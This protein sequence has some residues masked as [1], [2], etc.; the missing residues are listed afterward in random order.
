MEEEILTAMLNNLEIAVPD[1][2]SMEHDD[3]ALA[4]K[5]YIGASDTS[6]LLDVNLYKTK[7]ELIVEKRTKS[8]TDKERAVGE[9]PVV[10]KGFDLE[11]F[12]MGKYEKEF[13][14]KLIKPPHMYCFPNQKYMAINYDGV[15][16]VHTS[17]STVELIDVE[18]K[19]V[20]MYGEKYYNKEV[21]EDDIR[22]LELV[23][24]ENESISEYVKR[25]ASVCGIPAYYYTQ[26]QQQIAGLGSSYGYLYAWFDKSWEG[27]R[28][29]IPRD[30]ITIN[31]IARE[32]DKLITKIRS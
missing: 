18:I 31:A 24:R 7:G 13:D 12:I 10:K 16:V 27:K 20:S 3:Y 2:Q 32:G 5:E 25:A 19:F 29:Y 8:I 26:V 1:I 28:F 22:Q 6:V 15:S 21:T 9:K 17:F 4:R 14:I 11:D 23:R 30:T